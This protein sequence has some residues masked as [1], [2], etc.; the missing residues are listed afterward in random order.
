MIVFTENSKNE[1]YDKLKEL[2]ARAYVTIS[3]AGVDVVKEE[4]ENEDEL[5]PT[6]KT[7]IT[8]PEKSELA[9]QIVNS[10]FDISIGGD[11]AKS[12]KIVLESVYRASLASR[13][14]Q[15]CI[16]DG[17]SGDLEGYCMKLLSEYDNNKSKY[18]KVFCKIRE[19]DIWN[20]EKAKKAL[21]DIQEKAKKNS[22]FEEI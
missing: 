18:F 1:L 17:D 10:E 13:F 7:W 4:L 21:D 3:Y 20:E 5:I 6:Y 15:L 14:E 11:L 8:V 12:V 19:G 16:E 22:G 9:I 2:A